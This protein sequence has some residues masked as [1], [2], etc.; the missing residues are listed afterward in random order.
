MTFW[1][2]AGLAAALLFGLHMMNHVA[3]GIVAVEQGSASHSPQWS[4]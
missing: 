1:N 2:K 3:A 4:K